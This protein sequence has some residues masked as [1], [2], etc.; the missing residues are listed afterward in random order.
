MLI[1]T[2]GDAMVKVP[3]AW[4][5][6]DYSGLAS[7]APQGNEKTILAGRIEVYGG[8]GQLQHVLANLAPIEM[9]SLPPLYGS[10]EERPYPLYLRMRAESWFVG[11]I[12]PGGELAM[13][14]LDQSFTPVGKVFP[15]AVD[16]STN[17]IGFVA[18]APDV[19]DAWIEITDLG[20]MAAPP[21]ALAYRPLEDGVMSAAWA[22]ASAYEGKGRSYLNND[23]RWLV[24][25]PV[26][27]G[28]RWGYL[29]EDKSTTG[30]LWREVIHLQTELAKDAWASFGAQV[31]VQK[32]D[33]SWSLMSRT[34][35]EMLPQ[36]YA[37]LADT[38]A[39][40]EGKV[41]ERN[42]Q[43]QFAATVQQ[44]QVQ[45]AAKS[46][47]EERWERWNWLKANGQWQEL[48]QVSDI[49]GGDYFAAYIDLNPAP[50]LADVQRAMAGSGDALLRADHWN[51][52]LKAA[53]SRADENERIR[54]QAE[55]DVIVAEN[56][57]KFEES[58]FCP[59]GAALGG[60][61]DTLQRLKDCNTSVNQSNCAVADK[62]GIR[63][64]SRN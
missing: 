59:D 7:E 27:D 52:K 33:G 16:A 4:R 2:T 57:R 9:S 38:L 49:W 14:A 23:A 3:R 51:A 56:E 8:D 12:M 13:Q 44:A 20:E 30:P 17:Q 11:L 22:L 29:K 37:T 58:L 15:W 42:A 48:E 40:A 25:Y 28:V 10:S 24:A 39:A 5:S 50:R 31:A 18:P 32:L 53:R 47:E 35:G 26:E 19:P 60:Y 34:F 46:V 55:L 36:S 6:G 45:Q 64:C 54:Q 43:E 1:Y 21:G 41:L 63:S 62:G 61:V